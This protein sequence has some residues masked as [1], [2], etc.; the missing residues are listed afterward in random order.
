[1]ILGRSIPILFGGAAIWA[2]L[3][4]VPA[5][6]DEPLE[7]V[8][9]RLINSDYHWII[10]GRDPHIVSVFRGQTEIPDARY[11]LTGCRFCAGE[12]DNCENDGI[13]E[14]NFIS[15]PYE[16]ILAVTCHVG[17]HSQRL[18]I[19][20][21]WQNKNMAVYSVTGDY[22]IVHEQASEHLLIT[23]DMRKDDGTYAPT[24]EIWP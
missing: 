2:V 8:R 16:P 20:R 22:H 17:A 6:A 11:E 4:S 21:P 5:C 19:L 15:H 9:H 13:A 14:V 12:D 3:F 24:V 7:S 18:Q 1:M 23:Y 10:D